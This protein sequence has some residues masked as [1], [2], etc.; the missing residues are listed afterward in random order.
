M[1]TDTKNLEMGGEAENEE[2]TKPVRNI[3]PLKKK[4]KKK[5]LHGEFHETL[6]TS[7]QAD[8]HSCVISI[9]LIIVATTTCRKK[10]PQRP[11]AVSPSLL[12]E[13]INI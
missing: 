3:L 10:L 1:I 7:L 5:E 13:S 12:P 9:Q 8:S 11:Q 4:K 2:S 6:S